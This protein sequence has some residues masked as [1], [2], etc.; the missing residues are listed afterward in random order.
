MGD[1]IP[2]KAVLKKSADH[3]RPDTLYVATKN[4]DWRSIPCR[5]NPK[6]GLSPIDGRNWSHRIIGNRIHMAPSLLCT[7]TLFHTDYNWSVE[8]E[9]LPPG[10]EPVEFF[11]A[12]NPDWKAP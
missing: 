3:T 7:D 12:I 11:G 8:F 10:R 4:G 9:E 2:Y 5:S 6:P 1:V